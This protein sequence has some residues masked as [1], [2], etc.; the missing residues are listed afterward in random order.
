MRYRMKAVAERLGISRQR[1]WQ[2][3]KA[4]RLVPTG[5]DRDGYWFSGRSVAGLE[6]RMRARKLAP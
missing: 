5:E 2:Y 3:V 4:G 6:R 1:V